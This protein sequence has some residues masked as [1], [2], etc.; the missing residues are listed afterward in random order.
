ME[1]LRNKIAHKLSSWVMQHIATQEYSGY[2]ALMIQYGML[3][4]AQDDGDTSAYKNHWT[5]TEKQRY[6]MLGSFLDEKEG[7]TLT[8]K[9]RIAFITRDKQE[10]RTM[11]GIVAKA[12]AK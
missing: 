6:A 4:L 12:K 7:M 5:P 8:S 3:R 10:V 1:G 9:D 2:M 11:E